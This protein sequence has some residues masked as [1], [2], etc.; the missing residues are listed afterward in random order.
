[1][2]NSGDT[3][4]S[5]MSRQALVLRFLTRTREEVVQLRARLPEEPLALE[6][7]VLTQLARIAHKIGS[8]AEPFGYPEITVIAGAVEL[9]SHDGG[10]R[11]ARERIELGLRL[12]DK[13]SALEIYVEH[14][15]AEA[16]KLAAPEFVSAVAPSQ[17]PAVRRRP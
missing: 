8:T 2:A 9:L 5:Q 15:L 4:T 13:V 17:T 6:P 11:G 3:S 14:A 10:K 7:D 16:E 12:Q 1:V